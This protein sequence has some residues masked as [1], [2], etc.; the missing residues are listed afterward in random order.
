MLAIMREGD[1]LDL[2][3][4]VLLESFPDKEESIRA[5]FAFGSLNFRRKIYFSFEPMGFRFKS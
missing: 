2:I 5:G 1:G 3:E 4:F